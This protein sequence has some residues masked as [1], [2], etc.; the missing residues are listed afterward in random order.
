M[1]AITEKFY[2]GADTMQGVLYL[3][4]IFT[5]SRHYCHGQMKKPSIRGQGHTFR[6]G[7]GKSGIQTQ[8]CDTT[9]MEPYS[10]MLPLKP[11]SEF[12]YVVF[13][14]VAVRLFWH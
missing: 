5:V 11:F 6:K 9:E 10:P 3:A 14:V 12:S 7:G 8:V 4:L 13:I 1:N 2:F